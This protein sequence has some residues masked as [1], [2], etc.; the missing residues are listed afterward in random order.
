[1]SDESSELQIVAGWDRRRMNEA[2]CLQTNPNEH[3]FHGVEE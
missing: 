2:I 3:K 1:M